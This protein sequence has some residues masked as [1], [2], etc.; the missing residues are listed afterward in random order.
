MK[1]TN[2]KVSILATAAVFSLAA[3]SMA[4]A[5]DAP[6]AANSVTG[7]L[8]LTNITYKLSQAAAYEMKRDGETFTVVLLS[9][10]A[11]PWDKIQASMK[12]NN[13]SDEKLLLDQPYLKLFF[14]KSGK[15]SSY[16]SSD[17]HTSIGHFGDE[18]KAKF[19]RENGR[20]RGDAQTASEPDSLVKWA[21]DVSWNVAVGGQAAPAPSA[22]PAGPAKPSVTGE[23]QGNGQATKLAYVSAQPGEP[24]DGKPVTVMVFTEKDHSR[25]GKPA[26]KAGFGDYGSALI[27]SVLPDGKI[28]GCEVSHAAHSKRPFSS[29]GTIRTGQF[30]MGNGRIAGEITTDGEQKFFDQTWNVNLKFVAPYTAP[31][32]NPTVSPSVGKPRRKPASISAVPRQPL[33]NG[34]TD[35]NGTAAASP[36]AKP[37][38]KDLALPTGAKDIVYKSLVEQMT[39]RSDAAVVQLVNE[40]SNK[41]AAQGWTREKGSDLVTAKSA[42]LDR[43]LGSA[44]LTIFVKKDGQGSK[45]NIMS[46]GLAWTSKE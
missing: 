44:K 32:A 10:R 17:G 5:Q 14:D 25:D 12:E 33:S 41:L 8:T 43:H 19:S 21:F 26:M 3:I 4:T 27:V 2:R 31:D 18:V 42:I 34:N 46:D 40:F 7:T 38:A 29:A 20:A 6:P 9:D 36:V 30:E 22:V 15:I 1:G 28:I 23:F 24:F 45:V 16:A 11:V 13:G 39:F 35:N 37:N